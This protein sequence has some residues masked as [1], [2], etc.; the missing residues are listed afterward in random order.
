MLQFLVWTISVSL[1]PIHNIRRARVRAF[2]SSAVSL[3]SF[4]SSQYPTLSSS[5][6]DMSFH[7]SLTPFLSHSSQTL[8]CNPRFHRCN[9][10]SSSHDRPNPPSHNWPNPPSHNPD[11]TFYPFSF[12][13]PLSFPA[14]PMQRLLSIYAWA[15]LDLTGGNA[16]SSTSDFTWVFWRIK[17]SLLVLRCW[18]L[19][20]L[21]R[22]RLL[23]S[24]LATV[25]WV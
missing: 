23:L 8:L 22:P 17:S 6:S 1:W 19:R 3:L 21:R 16:A 11:H 2:S 25:F 24:P 10:Q 13:T 7:S 9:P 18:I 20:L 4:S 15:S 12:L 14:K 5:S